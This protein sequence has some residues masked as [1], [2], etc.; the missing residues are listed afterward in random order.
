MSHW[1][2][3]HA[4]CRQ[5]CFQLMHHHEAE[6]GDGPASCRVEQRAEEHRQGRPLESQRDP[7]RTLCSD[8]RFS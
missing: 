6:T 7:C 2:T 1:R 8:S 5:W 3:S 4:R